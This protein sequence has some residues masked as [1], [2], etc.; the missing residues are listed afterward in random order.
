MVEFIKQSDI[1]VYPNRCF[2]ANLSGAY[3]DV[4]DNSQTTTD[5]AM[6]PYRSGLFVEI[7][8]AETPPYGSGESKGYKLGLYINSISVTDYDNPTISIWKAKR[9]ITNKQG[10]FGQDVTRDIYAMCSFPNHSADP[11]FTE[12]FDNIKGGYTSRAGASGSA[13]V[14][15]GGTYIYPA[16]LW[17]I[18]NTVGKGI[19]G[20][21]KGSYADWIKY[22]GS[23]L[24]NGLIVIWCK[25]KSKLLD[26]KYHRSKEYGLID[27]TPDAP[28]E[29]DWVNTPGY[30][31]WDEGEDSITVYSEYSMSIERT[32]LVDDEIDPDLTE[33]FKVES[34]PVGSMVR[35]SDDTGNT[36]LMQNGI[37]KGY[38]TANTCARFNSLAG[39]DITSSD[40]NWETVFQST[41]SNGQGFLQMN[42]VTE[43]QIPMPVQLTKTH[44]T[45]SSDE[46]T[47]ST[48][49]DGTDVTVTCEIESMSE[50]CAES[51]SLAFFPS[52]GLALWFKNHINAGKESKGNIAEDMYVNF[53]DESDSDF[54]AAND[55]GPS[56]NIFAGFFL[57]RYNGSYYVKSLGKENSTYGLTTMAGAEKGSAYIPYNFSFDPDAS[58]TTA[59]GITKLNFSPTRMMHIT[60]RWKPGNNNGFELIFIDAATEEVLQDEIHIPSTH[61]AT[62]SP[63]PNEQHAFPYFTFATYNC[64]ALATGAGNID[65]RPAYT[66]LSGSETSNVSDNTFTQVEVMV[67]EISASNYSMSYGHQN[68]TITTDG[69]GQK[70]EIATRDG[71]DMSVTL[72]K[73]DKLTNI[74]DSTSRTLPLHPTYLSFGFKTSEE[75]K[76]EGGGGRYLYFSGFVCANNAGN[77]EIDNTHMKWAWSTDAAQLGK[78]LYS[79]GVDAGTISGDNTQFTIGNN[80]F[81]NSSGGDT[82]GAGL[83]PTPLLINEGFTQKGHMYINEANFVDHSKRENIFCSSRVM[84]GYGRSNA[85]DSLSTDRPQAVIVN[86]P[87]IFTKWK[88]GEVG[89][90]DETYRIFIFGKD[91]RPT[92]YRSGLILKEAEK[93]SSAGLGNDA[94]AKMSFNKDVRFSDAYMAV[95]GASKVIMSSAQ[96]FIAS[97]KKIILDTPKIGG[98][99]SE[100]DLN[101]YFK[102]GDKITVGF[103]GGFNNGTKTV[104]SIFSTDT[105][106]VTNAVADETDSD[107]VV[108]HLS[109]DPDLLVNTIGD[110]R[111]DDYYFTFISPERYWIFG[112][113]YNYDSS[114]TALPTKS[115]DSVILTDFRMNSG[116]VGS[117]DFAEAKF[118]ASYSEYTVT[119]GIVDINAWNLTPGA[120]GGAL[121][122]KE[123]FGHGA[124][125]WDEENGGGYVQKFVPELSFNLDPQYNLVDISGHPIVPAGE[126]LYLWLL[127]QQPGTTTS[128]NISNFNDAL[129]T[130]RPFLLTVYEDEIP[131]HPTLTVEPYKNDGFLPHYK[132]EASEDD[133]WYG[134][135]FIDNSQI[136]NQYHNSLYRIPLNEDLTGYATSQYST[137]IFLEKSDG[138]K[139]NPDDYL[140]TET[141]SI[142]STAR[143]I[144]TADSRIVDG[145]NV[146]GTGIPAGCYVDVISSTSFDLRDDPDT[147]DTLVNATQTIGTGGSGHTLTFGGAAEDRYDGLA[148]HAKRFSNETGNILKWTGAD[149]GV[150]TGDKFSFIC[151]VVPDRGSLTEKTYIAYQAS[152][153]D[154]DIDHSWYVAL[155]QQGQVEL[156]IQGKK[157][158]TNLTNIATVLTSSSTIP[159]DNESPTMI[160]WTLDNELPGGNVK[161][162]INGI[163]EASTGLLK[164]NNTN[165]ATDQ[166]AKDLVIDTNSGNFYIGGYHT[167]TKADQAFSGKI[168]ELAAYGDC[169]YPV[170]PKNGEFIWRKNVKDFTG[171]KATPLSYVSRLFI[172]D[173]HNIRGRSTSDVAVSPPVSFIKP[174]LGNRGD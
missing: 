67:D 41:A 135:L 147:H 19:R 152:T 59:H 55:G 43:D 171:D 89:A 61:G 90:D 101:D 151:H 161:L 157:E 106:V 117:A 95:T 3:K 109:G 107:S 44:G 69:L 2:S 39:S 82:I 170:N 116:S 139:V 74:S 84:G 24:P 73:G 99:G 78:Q 94:Y 65:H 45:S 129:D 118:G 159:R 88:S 1:S 132:W 62:T 20:H 70:I 133:L 9:G 81:F 131:K 121:E 48:A 33:F 4:F 92:Y 21:Y 50:I 13:I 46:A 7:P 165:N 40:D 125:N 173:Y 155:T 63:F 98:V 167:G 168:E 83:N 91:N 138:S 108:S 122:S 162:Y 79:T 85:G 31:A 66:G 86:A 142:N 71:P 26:N 77:D 23:T 57:Y 128:V 15:A 119:D 143:V 114:D 163:L 10:N 37:Y 53:Y 126:S 58:V 164:T 60:C 28:D 140:F 14:E 153:V 51:D 169:I 38:K 123:D 174:I 42:A 112:E 96:Q 76:I 136:N 35:F 64:A 6:S 145:V 68:A 144:H 115:Y 18:R 56:G 11:F 80:L 102:A 100:I 130:R 36:I 52:R 146:S 34:E 32:S 93:G 72:S 5:V 158:D 27:P 105:I 25:L 8:T 127:S 148:G 150:G 16:E 87:D 12:S 75:L 54:V 156:S 124:Y 172:K 154:N 120:A 113:V 141:A 166:W 97:S 111:Y 49:V 22:W 160:C 30:M 137:N 17:A 103:T 149:T 110:L 29:T 104:D 47:S 134:L